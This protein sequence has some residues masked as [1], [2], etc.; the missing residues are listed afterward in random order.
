MNA[1]FVQMMY[2][3]KSW[4]HFLTQMQKQK[5]TFLEKKTQA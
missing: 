3:S 4:T 1:M 2:S 5:D